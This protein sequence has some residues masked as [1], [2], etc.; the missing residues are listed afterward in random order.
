MET[1]KEDGTSTATGQIGSM[2][3]GESVESADN[4]QTGNNNEDDEENGTTPA[5]K[6]CSACGKESSAPQKCG[7]CRCV[8]YC[9]KE[10]QN[11]HWKVH[12]KECKRI[13][14]ELDKRGGKLDPWHRAGC[15]APSRTTAAGGVPNLHACIAAS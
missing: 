13:K 6:L 14:K 7:A 4:N 5:K 15:W 9:N 11:K 8:W 12:K 2:S 1:S 3:L 10:C